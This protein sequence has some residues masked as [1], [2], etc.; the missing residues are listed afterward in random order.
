MMRPIIRLGGVVGFLYCVWIAASWFR[1]APPPV[2]L[3]KFDAAL[4]E[5]GM[6]RVVPLEKAD[7]LPIAE[8]EPKTLVAEE[9]PAPIQPPPIQ[10]ANA[11]DLAQA[12]P[13]KPDLCERHH[14]HKIYIHGGKSW[15]CKK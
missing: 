3:E 9:P 13:H 7:R 11:I 4:R 2:D 6:I 8:P 12:T 10:Q 1:P 5:H 14:M 15:R